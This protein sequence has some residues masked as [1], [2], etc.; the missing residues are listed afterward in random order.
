MLLLCCWLFVCFFVT[1]YFFDIWYYYFD[2]FTG[3]LGF[4]GVLV[5][6]FGGVFW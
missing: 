1:V 3:G 4:C 6:I 2:L 5:L